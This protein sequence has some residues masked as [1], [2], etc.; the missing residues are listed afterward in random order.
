MSQYIQLALMPLIGALI[1]WG[2]NLFA[3][4]LIFR[5]LDP[6]KVPVLGIEI[7]GLIPKRRLDISKS[8]GEALEKE[9]ISTE[10]IIENLASEKNK[11]EFMEYIKNLIAAKITAK[12]PSIIPSGLR[13]SIATHIGNAI[14]Q[15]GND[16]FEEI[17][18]NL[19]TKAKEELNLKEMVEE[20]INSFDLKELED[21]IIQLAN[22]ELRQIEVLGGVMG[23]LVGIFQAG[24]T[25]VLM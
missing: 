15:D 12:L 1:G 13:N 20:K 23:F 16:I 3:V 7:Q 22:R 5:P 17:K 21:L 11:T 6:I 14:G 24:I 25:Y 19:V 10:E 4:K 9:I 8:I 2:T 18:Y